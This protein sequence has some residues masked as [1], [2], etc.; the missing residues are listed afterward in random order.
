[1]SSCPEQYCKSQYQ[2]GEGR[3]RG[4]VHEKRLINIYQREIQIKTTII[5]YHSIPMKM[6]H[7]KNSENNL[8]EGTF[9][10]INSYPLLAGKL[11]SSTPME[12]NTED[13]H[14]VRI[15]PPYDQLFHF[16]KSILRSKKHSFKKTSAHHY[17]LQQ[18]NS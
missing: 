3:K 15:E 9:W 8:L 13:C 11:P 7:N 1:M 6:A 14:K 4:K 17:S 10:K 5:I 12:S 2:K 18:Y 16:E